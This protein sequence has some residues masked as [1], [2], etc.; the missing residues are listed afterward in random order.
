METFCVSVPLPIL[1]DLAAL[2]PYG[3]LTIKEIINFLSELVNF[4]PSSALMVIHSKGVESSSFLLNLLWNIAH[5]ILIPVGKGNCASFKIGCYPFR[6]GRKGTW[7]PSSFNDFTRIFPFDPHDFKMETMFAFMGWRRGGGVS[8][9]EDAVVR[10]RLYQ[11]MHFRILEMFKPFWGSKD[12]IQTEW[13]F[14]N[15][16]FLGEVRA[17]VTQVFESTKIYNSTE[18]IQL[19]LWVLCSPY[20]FIHRK[21]FIKVAI[22]KPRKVKLIIEKGK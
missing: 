10:C 2:T 9:C 11:L 7:V 13:Y 21:Y 20:F 12:S 3:L 22:T 17:T 14:V 18:A 4:C 5:H 6:R 1:M 16:L 8:S 15:P 19:A